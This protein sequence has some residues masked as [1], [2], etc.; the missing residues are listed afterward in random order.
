[1]LAQMLKPAVNGLADWWCAGVPREVVAERLV[2][3]LLAGLSVGTHYSTDNNVGVFAP[4]L[5]LFVPVF[6]TFFVSILRL[7]Q[8]KSP[9]LGSK[10]HFAL[11]L[12]RL[13]PRVHALCSADGQRWFTVGHAALEFRQGCRN[14]DC[15]RRGIRAA[16]LTERGQERFNIYCSVC[17]GYQGDGHGTVGELRADMDGAAGT[18]GHTTARSWLEGP[19]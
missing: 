18:P 15:D 14:G 4:V 2:T 16:N 12:E 5:I 11:R 7:N 6:D 19:S 1:M 3:F 13:G 9:F 8:G 10:D 17:H